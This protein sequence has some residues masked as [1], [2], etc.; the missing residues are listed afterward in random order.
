M[1]TKNFIMIERFLLGRHDDTRYVRK[2]SIAQFRVDTPDERFT[3]D[4]VTY[5]FNDARR[6]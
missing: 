3:C 2:K 1:H 4:V 5:I 6:E